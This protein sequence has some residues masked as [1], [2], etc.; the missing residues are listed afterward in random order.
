MAC[1]RVDFKSYESF[2]FEILTAVLCPGMFTS[3]RRDV[4]T[5]ST[6]DRRAFAMRES[7]K[8]DKG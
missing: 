5:G 3:C 2:I 4:G 1:S 7:I 8:V 6:S